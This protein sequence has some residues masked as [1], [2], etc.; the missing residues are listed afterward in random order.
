M[1]DGVGNLEHAARQRSRNRRTAFAA[2]YGRQRFHPALG[3]RNDGLAARTHGSRK[4]PI[5]PFCR[6]VWQVAGDN[7]IPA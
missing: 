4:Q 6:K 5:D 7:Q 1:L 2:I 3:L